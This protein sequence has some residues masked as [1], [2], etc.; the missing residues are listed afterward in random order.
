MSRASARCLDRLWG[1]KWEGNRSGGV[2][3]RA[4]VLERNPASLALF[5]ACGFRAVGRVERGPGRGAAVL[6]GA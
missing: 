3:P 6:E 2:R 1:P 5:R 4:F